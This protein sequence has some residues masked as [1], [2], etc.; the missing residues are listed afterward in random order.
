MRKLLIAL[1]LVIILAGVWLWRGRDLTLFID[2]FETVQ[3]SSRSVDAITYNGTGN[4]GTLQVG[5]LAL[6]LNEVNLSAGRPNI[7]TTKE[8]ELAISYS[9]KVFPFGRVP[10]ETQQL[11][12]DRPPEDAARISISHS[13]LP[14]PN[15]FEINWMTGNS[16]KWKRN[17]YQK[18]TWKKPTGAKLKMIWRYEQFYY[19]QDRW[20]DALMTRPGATG[21]IRVEIS[22]GAAHLARATRE[23]I[24][25]NKI[26]RERET[27]FDRV[28]Q[29]VVKDRHEETRND[30]ARALHHCR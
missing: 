17:T 10:V 3:T 19:P 26:V 18:L 15:F 22:G 20:T 28:S 1:L 8:G 7:G 27:G 29:N 12:A 24:L 5:D 4:D 2:R 23:N 25:R 6:S 9:G 30:P 16:P 21:L 11:R 14:W 13:P